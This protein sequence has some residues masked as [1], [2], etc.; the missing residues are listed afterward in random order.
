[1]QARRSTFKSA[2]PILALLL[3]A[4]LSILMLQISL[5][6]WPWRD[7]TGF[8]ILKQDVVQLPLWRLAFQLHVATSSM[9]LL[10]GFTQFWPWLRRRQPRWHRRFGYLYVVGVLGLAAPTGLVLA[11]YASGGWPTQLCFVLLGL[12]W[13]GC[14]VLA[15]RRAQQRQWQAHQTWMIRS[16]ALTLA[17]LSLRTWKLGLYELAPYWDWLTPRHIY[18]LEA[19]LGWL[20]NLLIAEWLIYRLAKRANT[21]RSASPQPNNS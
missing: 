12:L 14:T 15:L 1:M 7:D 8:L 4:W 10:A 18:Q 16:Y 2:L 3:L 19:W 5:S 21:T 11:L 6:Y 20:V 13:I 9:V 17:A